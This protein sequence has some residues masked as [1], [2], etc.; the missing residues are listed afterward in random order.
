MEGS[1]KELMELVG[2]S[3]VIADRFRL[4]LQTS[5]LLGDFNA[6]THMTKTSSVEEFVFQVFDT[7]A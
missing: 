4:R 6:A 7:H 2:A 5:G 1:R 3:N